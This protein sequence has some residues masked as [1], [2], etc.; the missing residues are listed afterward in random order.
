M[1]LEFIE[2][3]LNYYNSVLKI[4]NLNQKFKPDIG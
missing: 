2:I 3:L 1:N 4:P